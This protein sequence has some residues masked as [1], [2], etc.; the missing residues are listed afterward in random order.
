MD[1]QSRARVG[2]VRAGRLLLNACRVP[3]GRARRGMVIFV[4]P[5]D[6]R[7]PTRT[8]AICDETDEHLAGLGLAGAGW[9]LPMTAS[10]SDT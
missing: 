1:S 5:G 9:A 8:P 10:A 7:D 2:A 3:L 6:E 4:P